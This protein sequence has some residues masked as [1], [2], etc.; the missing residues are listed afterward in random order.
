MLYLTS[1]I[2]FYRVFMI[3]LVRHIAV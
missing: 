3:L 2:L 1:Y